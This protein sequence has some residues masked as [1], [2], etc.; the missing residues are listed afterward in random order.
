M[1]RRGFWQLD[2]LSDGELQ[3]ELRMLLAN[4]ARTEARVVAHLAEVDARKLHLTMGAS[5]LFDYCLTRLELSNN[6]AFHRITAA[7]LARKFPL[8]FEMLE[9]RDVHLTAVCLLRDYLTVENHQ[10]LLRKASHKTKTQIEELLAQ[11]FPKPDVVSRVRKL[12]PRNAMPQLTGEMRG[13][14]DV[15]T[16]GAEATSTGVAMGGGAATGGGAP[17]AIEPLSGASYRLQVNA[18]AHLKRKIDRA[19]DL[20]SHANPSGDLAVLIERAF[21]A[22]LERLEAKRF[23]QT[24]RPRPIPPKPAKGQVS[25]DGVAEPAAACAGSAVRAPAAN[26]RGAVR[27]VHLPHHVRREVVERD[28]QRCTFTSVEG[29]RCTARAFLQFHHEK[30]WAIG[31]ADTAQN[32]KL[33]CRAHNRLIAE[34]EL[35]VA[36][37]LEAIEAKRANGARRRG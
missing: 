14:V 33:L 6:E 36:R 35:G 18:S 25:R 7:R 37:V 29:H 13:N 11:R 10:E 4:G 23:A 26:G 16:D 2:G 28:G 17:R 19:R 3:V 20:M 8:I 1:N 31:G 24:K 34:R 5:S 9:R 27:R 12:P 30:A 15:A 22:L 21:D 32:L